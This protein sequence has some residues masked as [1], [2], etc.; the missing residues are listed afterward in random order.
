MPPIVVRG[1]KDLV[2]VGTYLVGSK[3]RFAM[4]SK[5]SMSL[6]FRLMKSTMLSMPSYVNDL[7]THESEEYFNTIMRTLTKGFL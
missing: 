6:L 5:S 3:E 1:I 4:Y 7:K 2:S